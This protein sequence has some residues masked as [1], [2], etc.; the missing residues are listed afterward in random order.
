MKKK[1]GKP[2]QLSAEIGLF[3]TLFR[4]RSGGSATLS[5][6]QHSAQARFARRMDGDL[7]SVVNRLQ[8]SQFIPRFCRGDW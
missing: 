4:R 8:N 7:I 3:P 1:L 5:R 2:R 6:L